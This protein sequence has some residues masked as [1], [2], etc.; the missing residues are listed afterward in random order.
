MKRNQ[1]NTVIM[2]ISVIALL[3]FSAYAFAD[4]GMGYGRQAMGM[5]DRE[6]GYS[7]R[8]SDNRGF[9]YNDR[10]YDNPGYRGNSGP[11]KTRRINPQATG[12]F[13]ERGGMGYGMMG[14][15]M[16][17]SGMMGSGGYCNW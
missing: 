5:Y 8:G 14:S 9:N 1:T 16:M 12:N 13:T 3:G 17:N 10:T 7:V 4:W 6:M 2:I 11:N 15:G